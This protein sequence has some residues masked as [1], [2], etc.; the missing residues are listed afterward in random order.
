LEP[1]STI[2]RLPSS[3]SSG[4]GTLPYSPVFDIFS[5]SN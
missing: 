1:S 3:T 2:I 5:P 4:G